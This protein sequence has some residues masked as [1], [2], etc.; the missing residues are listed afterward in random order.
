[1][2]IGWKFSLPGY[3]AESYGFAF[4]ARG[5]CDFQPEIFASSFPARPWPVGAELNPVSQVSQVDRNIRPT[6]PRV[7][8]QVVL[9]T[10]CMTNPSWVCTT[11]ATLTSTP[12]PR[13]QVGCSSQ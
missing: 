10:G 8:V 5:R 12:T 9:Q 13:F 3:A 2:I 11:I 6:G 4:G 1:V 7:V